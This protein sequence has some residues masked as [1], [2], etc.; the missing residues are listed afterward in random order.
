MGRGGYLIKKH[1]GRGLI[2][3]LPKKVPTCLGLLKKKSA[4]AR[5]V[6][7]VPCP[8]F[9]VATQLPEGEHPCTS[10]RHEYAQIV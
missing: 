5:H 8:E 9:G 2:G 10:S 7:R 1:K 4:K 3:R 6:G